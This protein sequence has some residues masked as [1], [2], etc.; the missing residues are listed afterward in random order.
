MPKIVLQTTEA[1]NLRE[2]RNRLARHGF[3]SPLLDLRMDHNEHAK[4]LEYLSFLRGRSRVF[5]NLLPTQ[6]SG[7]WS[8]TNP[9]L[10][11]FPDRIR[12]GVLPASTLTG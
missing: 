4:V 6:A 10:V 9:P 11:N 1:D 3:E 12:D 5:H 7:R 8:V 2:L